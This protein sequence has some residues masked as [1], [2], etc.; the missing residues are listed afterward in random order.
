MR[1]VLNI[2]LTITLTIGFILLG[3]FVF[4]SSYIRLG[5]AFK[6]FGLSVAYY[7]CVMFGI[8]HNI[9]PTVNIIPEVQT[10]QVTLPT[11]FDGFKDNSAQYFSLL[12]DKGNFDGWLAHISGVMADFQRF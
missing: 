1:R 2:L 3:V 7:F 8:R 12:I 4:R 5:Y 10:P 11:D 9:T 6:D